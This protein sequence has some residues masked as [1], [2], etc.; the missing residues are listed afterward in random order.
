MTRLMSLHKI[1]CRTLAQG[2]PTVADLTTAFLARLAAQAAWR[3]LL[4]AIARRRLAAIAAVLPNCR[5]NSSF[6]C[7]KRAT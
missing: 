2:V 4:Q 1:R 6:S 3:R 5:R 7:V